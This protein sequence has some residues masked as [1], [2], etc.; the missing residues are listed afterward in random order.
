MRFCSSFVY[1]V[2]VV[3]FVWL[4]VMIDVFPFVVIIHVCLSD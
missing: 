3:V 2:V 1:S 4:K